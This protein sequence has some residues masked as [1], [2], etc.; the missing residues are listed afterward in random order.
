MYRYVIWLNMTRNLPIIF[1]INFDLS[2]A[3]IHLD[4]MGKI[5]GHVAP[6]QN[7]TITLEA[8][9]QP[10]PRAAAPGVRSV[11]ILAIRVL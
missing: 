11:R 10:K 4:A 9:T 3:G 2:I 8:T 5:A 7:P 6:K 1:D